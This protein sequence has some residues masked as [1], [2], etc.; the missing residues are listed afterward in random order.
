MKQIKV[1]DIFE[2]KNT[3]LKVRVLEVFPGDFYSTSS[4]YESIIIQESKEYYYKKDDIK[5]WDVSEDSWIKVASRRD[6]FPAWW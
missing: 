3:G 6:H 1:G 2:Y 4:T 5:R